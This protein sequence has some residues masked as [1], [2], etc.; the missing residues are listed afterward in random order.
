[1]IVVQDDDD[2]VVIYLFPIVVAYC[3][4]VVVTGGVPFIVD[5]SIS[6]TYVPIIGDCLTIYPCY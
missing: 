1:M 3:L 6:G 4:S 5:Y 2:D